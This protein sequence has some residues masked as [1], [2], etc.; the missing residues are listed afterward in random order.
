MTD[1]SSN[2]G[3]TNT[4]ALNTAS[5]ELRRKLAEA[6]LAELIERALTRGFFGTCGVELSIHDGNIQHV[7]KQL[8]QFERT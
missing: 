1:S 5:N 4:D 7:R 3:A 6:A 2:A 8:E